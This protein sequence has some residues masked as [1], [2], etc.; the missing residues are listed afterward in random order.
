MEVGGGDKMLTR[1]SQH[2][3]KLIYGLDCI[4]API[5]H[6]SLYPYMCPDL[7]IDGVQFP[8]LWLQIWPYDLL[9][10]MGRSE[11]GS[12]QRLGLK[13]PC[14]FPLSLLCLYQHRKLNM[15]PSRKGSRK[16]W[17]G[18]QSCPGQV[19]PAK[20]NLVQLNSSH[21]TDLRVFGWFVTQ[22]EL[23]IRST[24]KPLVTK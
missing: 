16:G 24:N 20:L 8:E 21:S 23:T 19:S 7:I 10:P 22:E 13:R 4:I 14:L 2:K 17:E 3:K 11:C 18:E 12:T 15:P 5:P 1:E 6:A 9:W